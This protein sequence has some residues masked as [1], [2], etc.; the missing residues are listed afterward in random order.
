MLRLKASEI[1]L[2]AA[3]VDETL[4]RMERRQASNPPTTLP[5]RIHGPRL[6]PLFGPRMR[7]GPERSRDDAIATL[8]SIPILRPHEVVLSSTDDAYD[9][10]PRAG[11]SAGHEESDS[12]SGESSA[13]SL[14]GDQTPNAA[15][16]RLRVP[17]PIGRLDLPFRPA[18]SPQRGTLSE[19]LPSSPPRDL[20]KANRSSQE[21]TALSEDSNEGTPHARTHA[22]TDGQMDDPD[23]TQA[24]PTNRDQS[25]RQHLKPIPSP[26]QYMLTINSL[27]QRGGSGDP[28]VVCAQTCLHRA[29]KPSVHRPDDH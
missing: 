23:T 13:S 5:A 22:A 26:L 14:A 7:R 28:E 29:R 27:H 1:T 24:T 19:Y 15:S 21:R 9:A 16:T 3:D 8:G 2:T 10:S 17:V 20:Q 4:H 6:P 11:A 25:P 12:D 18:R